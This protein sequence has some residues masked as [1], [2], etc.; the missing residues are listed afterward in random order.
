MRTKNLLVPLLALAALPSF[1]QSP[2]TVWRHPDAEEPPLSAPPKATGVPV[3]ERELP[4]E[5]VPVGEAD[6]PPATTLPAS[7][8]PAAPELEPRLLGPM[9]VIDV[10]HIAE[11][12][13][14][15][16]NAVQQLERLNRLREKADIDLDTLAKIPFVDQDNETGRFLAKMLWILAGGDPVTDTLA[17]ESLGYSRADISE[18][19]RRYF[20]GERILPGVGSG[21]SPWDLWESEADYLTERYRAVLA[22]LYRT[23]DIYT[24]HV[25]QNSRER[26]GIMLQRLQAPSADGESQQSQML[27]AALHQSLDAESVDRQLA[28]LRANAELLLAAQE[29]DERAGALAKDRAFLAGQGA[30]FAELHLL[31]EVAG[32]RIRP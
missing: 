3:G 25:V 20:P 30:R 2:L 1:A 10:A 14:V 13:R 28:M 23:M 27:L 32:T 22:A 15:L 17:E 16:A 18:A 12:V 8:S 5:T 26:Q 24:V 9:P 7:A 31:S 21:P 11:T 19:F 6:L 4:P 29:V